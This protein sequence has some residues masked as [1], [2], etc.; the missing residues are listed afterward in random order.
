MLFRASRHGKWVC[1]VDENGVP[2]FLPIEEAPNDN[3]G[4]FGLVTSP[5]G[6]EIHYTD[7]EYHRIVLRREQSDVQE[8]N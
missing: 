4:A 7:D 6:I 3:S 2:S 8:R 1:M 5:E